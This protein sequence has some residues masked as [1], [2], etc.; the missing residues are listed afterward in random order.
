MRKHQ[1]TTQKKGIV[2][3][4][5]FVKPEE[6]QII[7]KQSKEDSRSVSNFCGRI[8]LKEIFKKEGDSQ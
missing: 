7:E 3:I 4:S 2:Q 1:Y 8:I 6:K 5:F